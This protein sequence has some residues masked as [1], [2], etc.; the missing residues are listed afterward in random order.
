MWIG[1][2]YDPSVGEHRWV[3]GS[4]MTFNGWYPGRSSIK[5]GCVDY[6]KG[7]GYLWN[8]HWDC[9]NTKGAFICEAGTM[10]LI[11]T[12]SIK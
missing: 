11:I 7:F 10:K 9:V 5:K 3:D 1:A 4:K 12:K 6:L 2:R 8:T